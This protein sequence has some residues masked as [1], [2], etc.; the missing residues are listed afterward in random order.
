M[1]QFIKVLKHFFNK[2]LINCLIVQSDAA[3]RSSTEVGQS[4]L[5]DQ[6][7]YYATYFFNFASG[8]QS[9]STTQVLICEL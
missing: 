7:Q 3:M 9:S 4:Q 6:Q 2:F 8:I 1:F 5:T